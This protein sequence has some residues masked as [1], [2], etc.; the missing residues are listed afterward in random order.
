M[1]SL[2][3]ADTHPMLHDAATVARQILSEIGDAPESEP[4]SMMARNTS[5]C[6]R[7]SFTETTP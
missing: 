4:V 6:R 7:L 1:S 3:G 5:I 2:Q